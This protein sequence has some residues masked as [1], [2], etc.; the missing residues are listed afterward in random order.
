MADKERPNVRVEFPLTQGEVEPA[1][2]SGYAGVQFEVRGEADCRLLVS[3]YGN[4]SAADLWATGFAVSP[5]WQTVQLPFA[6][7]KRRVA[8]TWGG[9]DGRAILVELGGAPRAG[10]WVELDNLRLYRQ[11]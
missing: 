6:E 10:V 4:R 2:V 7:L 3:A 11:Q 5:E 8:G 9:R 1:D